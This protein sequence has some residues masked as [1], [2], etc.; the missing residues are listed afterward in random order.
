M[1]RR[2]ARVDVARTSL[3]D[4]LTMRGLLTSLPCLRRRACAAGNGRGRRGG[5]GSIARLRQRVAGRPPERYVRFL[6]RDETARHEATFDQA[7]QRPLTGF[8]WGRAWRRKTYSTSTQRP[9]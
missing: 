7:K 1:G 6:A 4:G 3:A 9:P 2:D 5:P 8:V